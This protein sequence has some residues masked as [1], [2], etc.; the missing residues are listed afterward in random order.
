MKKYNLLKVI[1]ITIVVVWV[2]TLIIP[3]SYVD[4]SGKIVKDAISAK[5]VWGLLSD[6]NISI[7]YFNGIA[8]F[9]IAISCFYGV[10]NKTESYNNFINKAVN[11]FSGKERLLSSLSIILFGTMAALVS[12]YLVLLLFMPLVYKLMKKLNIDNKV[13]LA[14][15]ILPCITGAMFGIYNKTLFNM[16]SLKLNTLLLIKVIMLVISLFVLIIFVAPKN[17]KIVDEIKT[18]KKVVSKKKAPRKKVTK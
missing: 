10:L 2:L 16:F 14:S 18:E 1:A 17:K 9:L 11:K 5:G 3:G 6:T 8:V 4:Y 7:S 13:I 12:D 15:T